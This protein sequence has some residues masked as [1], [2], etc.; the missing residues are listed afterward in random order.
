MNRAQGAWGIPSRR[1]TCTLGVGVVEGEKGA[2]KIFEEIVTKNFPNL[3]KNMNIKSKYDELREPHGDTS[4]S[5]CGETEYFE[6]G[7][8]EVTHHIQEVLNEIISRFPIRTFGGQKAAGCYIQSVKR[9]KNP[10]T[11]NP[12]SSKIQIQSKVKKS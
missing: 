11:K 9:K 5:N 2:E 10:S 1:P 8:R 6:S 12:I 3:K 7:K 4:Q